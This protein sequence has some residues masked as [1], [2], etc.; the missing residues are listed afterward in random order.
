MTVP[1]PMEVLV[2]VV[3]AVDPAVGASDRGQ[4]RSGMSPPGP[5]SAAGWPGRSRTGRSC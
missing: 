4:R 5:A 2:S 3:K 1:D